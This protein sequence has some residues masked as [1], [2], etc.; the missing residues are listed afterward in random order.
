MN[1]KIKVLLVE[2]DVDLG[3]MLKLY[4]EMDKFSV[5]VTTSAE[6]GMSLFNENNFTI[7]VLDV[8]LPKMNG[9]DFAEQIRKTNPGFPFVFLTANKLKE[10]KIRGLKLG[11]DDYITKPFDAEELVLRIHNILNRTGDL[12]QTLLQFLR[13]QLNMD[14]LQLIHP[15]KTQKLTRREAELLYYFMTNHNKLIKTKDILS[16]LWGEDDYFL[17]R[18]MNVFIS[19]IRKYLSLE[20]S[21]SIQ[22]VRGE[23]YKLNVDDD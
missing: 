12:K 7:G 23:G 11:A 14:E 1:E 22:N 13:F 8:N 17:G 2:D 15:E 20:P 5:Y 16:D 18:S 10:D 6:K 21:I 19:R 3:Q 4:L 9:F